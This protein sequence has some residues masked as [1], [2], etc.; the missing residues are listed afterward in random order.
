[1]LTALRKDWH[2]YG[3]GA[4]LIILTAFAV[5]LIAAFCL[6]M[7]GDEVHFAKSTILGYLNGASFLYPCYSTYMSPLAEYL[8]SWLWKGFGPSLITLRLPSAIFSSLACGVWWFLLAQHLPKGYRFWLGCFLAIP[9]YSNLNY[10]LPANPSYGL[11]HL[12]IALLSL[13]IVYFPSTPANRHWLLLGLA[14]GLALHLFPIT[15]LPLVP[16]IAWLGLRDGRAWEILRTSWDRISRI[17]RQIVTIVAIA[18]GIAFSLGAYHYFTRPSHYQLPTKLL[19]VWALTALAAVG[20]IGWMTWRARPLWNQTARIAIVLGIC[21]ATA[22]IPRAVF[23]SQFV[24]LSPDAQ[25]EYYSGDQTTLEQAHNWGHRTLFTIQYLLTQLVTGRHLTVA[26]AAEGGYVESMPFSLWRAI[27]GLCVLAIIMTGSIR[28][29]ENREARP[30]VTLLGG[31]L[32]LLTV[33]LMVTYQ[34]A[35]FYNFRYLAIFAP[36]FFYLAAST[37][38]STRVGTWL[39]GILVLLAANDLA[40]TLWQQWQQGGAR[41][42]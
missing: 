15:I 40:Q 32:L 30:L 26:P 34:S 35:N 4:C 42:L 8:A 29:W 36:G 25:A 28:A 9:S 5:R 41:L 24:R 27:L 33:L 2:S 13:L 7:S 6:T 16:G 17:E 23:N 10:V 3:T 20:L 19:P 14:G 38:R 1:M 21:W 18:G 11:G 37:F 39:L 22:A 31:S 12:A